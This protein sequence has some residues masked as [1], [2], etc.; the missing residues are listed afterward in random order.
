M[1]ISECENVCYN[2][3]SKTYYQKNCLPVPKSNTVINK[4]AM[5]VKVLNTSVT[6]SAVFGPQ[7]TQAVTSVAQMGEHYVTFFPL[8][9]VWYLF[10][11]SI[12]TI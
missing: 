4:G 7:W 10:Y 2:Q 1:P 6:N 12:V 5:M 8:V 11:G 3:H 9:K